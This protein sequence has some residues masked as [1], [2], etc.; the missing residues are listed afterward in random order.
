MSKREKMAKRDSAHRREEEWTMVERHKTE[1]CFN[2]KGEICPSSPKYALCHR[3]CLVAVQIAA[4][5]GDK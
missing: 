5:L 4:Y 1:I 2:R 3:K